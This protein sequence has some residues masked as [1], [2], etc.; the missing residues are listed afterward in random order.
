MRSSCIHFT[1]KSSTFTLKS[2]VCLIVSPLQYITLKMI[3]NL[4]ISLENLKNYSNIE[5]FETSH[6]IKTCTLCYSIGSGIP[7]VTHDN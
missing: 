1:L 5:N 3:V 4:S 2:L 6:A 7:H